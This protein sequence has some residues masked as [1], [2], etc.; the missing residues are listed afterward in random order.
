MPVPSSQAA[1]NNS[2]Q[3]AVADFTSLAPLPPG[4]PRLQSFTF[5]I[6]AATYHYTNEAYC[7]EQF[8]HFSPTWP[9]R[10]V[11]AR[12]LFSGIGFIAIAMARI[13][14]VKPLDRLCFPSV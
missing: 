7:Q 13:N 8:P 9:D 14:F 5:N 10:A 12:I 6:T 4:R 3:L 2:R 11:T 1:Q